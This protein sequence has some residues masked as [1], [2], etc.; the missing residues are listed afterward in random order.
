MLIFAIVLPS[1]SVKP[2]IPTK[3]LVTCTMFCP[4]INGTGVGGNGVDVELEQQLPPF[5]EP[6]VTAAANGPTRLL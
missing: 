6:E 5:W 2:D 1:V 4:S 3:L